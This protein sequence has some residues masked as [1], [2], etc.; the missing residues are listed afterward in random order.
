MAYLVVPVPSTIEVRCP[1]ACVG[2]EL[3]ER[4]YGRR[5]ISHRDLWPFWA[6]RCFE[7]V[8]GFPGGPGWLRPGPGSLDGERMNLTE[9]FF[10]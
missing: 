2:A 8:S 4:R 9:I 5:R 1:S 10:V 6:P 3:R 7:W